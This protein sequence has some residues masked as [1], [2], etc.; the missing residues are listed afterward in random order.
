MNKIQNL[1]EINNRMEIYNLF[2]RVTKK[3][4]EEKKKNSRN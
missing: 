4:R 1:K 3:I 2:M